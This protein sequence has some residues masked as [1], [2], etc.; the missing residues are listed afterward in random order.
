MQVNQFAIKVFTAKLLGQPGG[1]IWP[2][3][4]GTPTVTPRH[5]PHDLPKCLCYCYCYWPRAILGDRFTE[6]LKY[7]GSRTAW[8][9]FRSK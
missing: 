5:E 3:F 1:F 4:M 7:R 2:A 8:R 9:W 6:G